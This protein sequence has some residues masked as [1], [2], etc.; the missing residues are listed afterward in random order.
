LKHKF[1]GSDDEWAAVLSHFLLQHPANNKG[2]SLDGVRLVYTLKEKQLGLSLRQD[3]QGIKVRDI[4]WCVKSEADEAQVTLGEIVLPQDDDFEF[5]P[6]HWAR[7]SAKAHAAT[8][9]EL[10][11]LKSRASSEQETI[12]KL[13]AQLDDFIKTK[14]ETETAMLRQFMQL[15]N[16]KKRKIRDQSRLLAGA[17]VDSALGMLCLSTQPDTTDMVFTATTV[18]A[19][20]RDTKPRKAGASRESKRKAPERTE[21][22]PKPTSDSDQMEIDEAPSTTPDASDD[23]TDEDESAAL[24]VR[25]KSSE[26]L[27]ASSV[28][29]VSK[30]DP[31]SEGNPPPKR[32]LPFGRR[33]TRSKQ[34]EKQPSPPP[35]P[36][37][38]EDTD[39]EE[40]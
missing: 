39:D 15:L 6:F 11:D 16:E 12:A 37:D 28:A 9:Q 17:K 19:S 31:P 2:T 10:A 7:V 38:D 14:N 30:E 1:K 3:V 13:N 4:P 22:K 32:E 40:L 5:D 18:Q 23:E 33:A 24:P 27:R 20:R 35:P 21:T 25:E 34:P 8:L 36:D 29:Q 26:T